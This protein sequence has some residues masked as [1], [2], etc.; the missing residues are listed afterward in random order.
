MDDDQ[1]RDGPVAVVVGGGSGIG[2]AVAA[3]QRDGGHTVV[4][5]DVAGPR[6]VD[7]D[8]TD[9][10]GVDTA[11]AATEDR[12]GVPAVLTVSAGIGHAG[13]LTDVEPA[14]WDRVMGVNAKGVW[15]VM[16]AVARR[17]RATGTAGSVVVTSSISSR[18][19][20]RNM[21]L[22]CASKA[23]LDMV[24]RVAAA[25]WG[26]DGIRVN[27]VAPGVTRT[28]MLGPA[29]TDSGWLAGVRDRTPLD[30]LGR[31]EDVA[32]AAVALHG[33]AWVTGQVLDCDGGLGLASPIDSYGAMLAA[34]AARGTSTGGGSG[35]VQ[36][37]GG[38]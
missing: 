12:H 7:C 28:P 9:A 18:V 36:H 20:D 8:I 10:D 16:R 23:A 21:G 13:L 17:W 1:H 32:E 15:L 37:N 31:A 19:A 25:E 3:R 6:D 33:L 38:T 14:E 4:V 11:L 27:A 5:W 26:P 34:R 30:R 22:Y 29:P 2:A 24:V 35:R